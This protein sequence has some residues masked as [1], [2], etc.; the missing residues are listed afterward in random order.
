MTIKKLLGG[1]AGLIYTVV[2]FLALNVLFVWLS[3]Y[4]VSFTWIGA[5][6]FWIF[7]LPIIIGIFQT[8]A[9]LASL[10]IVYLMKE[11]RYLSL[12]LIIPALYC[13]FSLGHFLW[14]LASSIGGILIWLL[15]ITWFGET[16]WFFIA[17]LILAISSAFETS[18]NR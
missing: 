7:G 14:I 10:P 17:C 9:S 1:G 8:I 2:L 18:E 13:V 6:V 12:L 15:A 3:Q 16:A 5:A 11:T 4:L